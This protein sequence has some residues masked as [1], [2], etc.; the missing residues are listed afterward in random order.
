MMVLESS[1]SSASEPRQFTLPG[2]F[3]AKSRVDCLLDVSRR[4]L[5]VFSHN[6]GVV[7]GRPCDQTKSVFKPPSVL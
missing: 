7:V 5:V 1:S 2:L 6:E 4:S 3:C